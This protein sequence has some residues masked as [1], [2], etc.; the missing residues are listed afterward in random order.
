MAKKDAKTNSMVST[1]STVIDNVDALLNKMNEMKEAQ[2]IFQ[3]T[4]KNK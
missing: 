1:K 3:P 4:H 2:R